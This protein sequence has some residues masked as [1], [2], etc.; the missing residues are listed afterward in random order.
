MALGETYSCASTKLHPVAKGIESAHSVSPLVSVLPPGPPFAKQFAASG[1]LST[2][3]LPH[4]RAHSS[5]DRC[6]FDYSRV[7]SSRNLFGDLLTRKSP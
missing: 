6:K 5:F 7:A 3:L 1:K 4:K 2:T